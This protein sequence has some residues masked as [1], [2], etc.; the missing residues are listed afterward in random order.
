MAMIEGLT[1]LTFDEMAG[2]LLI[3]YEAAREG[4]ND[5][6]LHLVISKEGHVL[7]IADDLKMN[8]VLKVKDME[9]EDWIVWEMK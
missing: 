7:M 9:A 2:Y 5:N 3:G 6:S 8:Y 4:W 1:G